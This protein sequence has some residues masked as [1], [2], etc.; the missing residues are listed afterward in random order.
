MSNSRSNSFG[1]AQP[2]DFAEHD[3]IGIIRQHQPGI[4]PHQIE[5]AA[6]SRLADKVRS[7]PQQ[8]RHRMIEATHQ[9]AVDEEKIGGHGLS[10]RHVWTAPSRQEH[11]WYFGK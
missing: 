8:R 10:Y 5:P 11:F 7:L 2:V 1:L 3:V 4:V 6:A 9:R